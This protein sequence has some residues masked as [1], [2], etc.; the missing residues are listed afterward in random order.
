MSVEGDRC[1][2]AKRKAAGADPAAADGENLL[3]AAAVL[4]SKRRRGA[5]FNSEGLR[6]SEG[7]EGAAP[8]G[9]RLIEQGQLL[10]DELSGLQRIRSRLLDS[11]KKRPSGGGNAADAARG[12]QAA[13]GLAAVRSMRRFPGSSVLQCL[14]LHV[15]RQL[16]PGGGGGEDDSFWAGRA[17]PAVA[18][19]AANHGRDAAVQRAATALAAG[20]AERDGACRDALQCAVGPV[21]AVFEHHRSDAV[22][23]CNAAATLCWL[24][25]HRPRITGDGPSR[26]ASLGTSVVSSMKMH[27]HDALVF[28]NCVCL[29]TAVDNVDKGV[30]QLVLEGMQEH[31]ASQI[32]QQGCLRWL[33]FDLLYRDVVE[34]EV[35]AVKSFVPL[36]LKAMH[37]FAD[38]PALQVCATDVLGALADRNAEAIVATAATDVVLTALQR[39]ASNMALQLSAA[40]YLMAVG[41][42][43]D[44][45]NRAATRAF[46]GDGLVVLERLWRSSGIAR[47]QQRQQEEEENNEEEETTQEDNGDETQQQHEPLAMV[48]MRVY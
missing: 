13:A 25:H 11:A 4:D 35:C 47:Q 24:L 28:G 26:H 44:E 19:A 41:S 16:L 3:E 46:G 45:Q 17:A 42:W 37:R 22:I 12:S 38:T 32:V 34:E 39:H 31:A 18:A 21:V 14:G 1:G 20:L 43:Q 5:R 15:L 10:L 30:Y 36:V 40:W 8:E 23:Q 29:L 48:N 6:G 7:E 27:L 33:C 2:P 9:R